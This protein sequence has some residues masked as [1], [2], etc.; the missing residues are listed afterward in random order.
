MSAIHP[1][2]DSGVIYGRVSDEQQSGHHSQL[3]NLRALAR[4]LAVRVVQEVI[5]EG[6][7]G[8]DLERPGLLEVCAIYERAHQSSRPIPWLLVDHSDR[9]SRA[10]SIDT[11][12]LLARLRRWGVRR[13][14]TPQRVFDLH[15]STDRLLLVLECDHRNNPHLKETA[16]KTLNGMLDI[17][18]QG[19]WTGGPIPYGYRLVKEP[20]EHGTAGSGR[21][22]RRQSGRL[23]VCPTAGPIVAEVFRRWVAGESSLT[24]LTYLRQASGRNWHRTA[25]IDMVRRLIYTGVMAFGAKSCGKHARLRDGQAHVVGQDDGQADVLHLAVHPAIIAPETYRL[26]QSR[27]DSSKHRSRHTHLKRTA[28]AGLIRC[29]ICDQHMT[30]SE[31]KGHRYY[32]CQRDRSAT[33]LGCQP[34]YHVRRQEAVSRV[35]TLLSEQLLTGDTVANL[36]RL[37]G[38]ANGQARR[39]WERRRDEAERAREAIEAQMAVN[40]RRLATA[41]DDMVPE[42]QRIIRE[43]REEH[44]RLCADERRTLAQ[45]PAADGADEARLRAW[46][47]ACRFA[48]D[49][50][51]EQDDEALNALL[52]RLVDSVTVTPMAKR[53]RG[54]ATIQR[55]AVRLPLW[56]SVLCST[57]VGNGW[58]LPTGEKQ[59]VSAAIILVNEA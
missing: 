26:A 33:G 15:S 49:S 13:I 28:L 53:V 44:E 18:K 52:T 6:E 36:V 59:A 20:G 37:A 12:E 7:S 1:T 8:D 22:K 10:D 21:R 57:P 42:Y 48:C 4:E 40:R 41:D 16:R 58:P 50:G 27:F 43:L 2:T 19:F 35:L 56:L 24:I 55:V 38:E 47:D 14:A 51:A 34:A 5:D 25:V 11:N 32:R 39:D 30:A 54:G 29:G 31:Q 23:A 9:L 45:E 46:L 17:A 3:T